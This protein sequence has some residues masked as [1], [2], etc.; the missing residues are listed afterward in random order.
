MEAA[1]TGARRTAAIWCLLLL[2]SCVLCFG[3]WD[4]R[5]FGQSIWS[6]DGMRRLALLAASYGI[7]SLLAFRIRA[8]AFL[9]VL[10]GGALLYVVAALGYGPPAAALFLAVAV[11]LLGDMVLACLGAR[12]E[13]GAFRETAALSFLAGAALVC[14]AVG[15][16]VHFPVNYPGV[17]LAALAVPLLANRRALPFYAAGLMRAVRPSRPCSAAAFAARALLGF[18]VLAHFLVAL[19]PEA[20]YDAL[21]VHMMAP[22]YVRAHYAWSFDIGCYAW[23]VMPMAG[24]WLF[25]AAYM[26]GGEFAARL[27]N[28]AALAAILALLYS[29]ARR[30]LPRAPAALGVALF[31]STPLVQLVT[32]S[33]FVE[34]VLAAMILAAVVALAR[35]HRTGRDVYLFAVGLFLGT[36]LSVK[37]GAL[38]C[39][40]PLAGFA[41]HRALRPRIPRPGLVRYALAA[42]AALVLI[43]GFPY[44]YAWHVAGSPMYPFTRELF[45]SPFPGKFPPV[46]DT[47]YRLTFHSH[48]YLESQDGAFGFHYLLFLPVS[49]LFFS[50]RVPYAA[51]VAGVTAVVSGVAVICTQPYLRYLYPAV[52]LV[53]IVFF[54]MLAA[55]S[56][57]QPLLFRALAAVSTVLVL[58]NFYYMP[59]SGWL[60]RDFFLPAL[61]GR[62]TVETYIR[63]MAPVRGIIAYLNLNSPGEPAWFMGNNYIAGLTGR[64]YADEWHQPAFSGEVHRLETAGD[65]L[66]LARKHGLRYFIA[67]AGTAQLTDEPAA[68]RAFLD[69]YTSKEYEFGAMALYRLRDG[70]PLSVR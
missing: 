56:K 66:A 58:L 67:P 10:G 29:L 60:H 49:L 59:A 68:L 52:V 18:I 42:L 61:F 46:W 9:S 48:E 15:I 23:A 11:L 33:L 6:P 51:W 16:A 34:N 50:L 55:A 26:L 25:T 1:G 14:L 70:A 43:G 20:G 45:V 5:L 8:T 36:A 19:K 4:G 24:D 31:A 64:A 62:Q 57:L 2:L 3:F 39:A 44:V 69:Q 13:A 17:Y 63:D 40:V 38:S 53:S 41:V 7:F 35:L 27:T 21:A 12:R 22:A 37:L 28:F 54:A 30:W 32:G 47:L 65:A